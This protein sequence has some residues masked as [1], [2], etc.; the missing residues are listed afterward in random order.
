MTFKDHLARF[1]IGNISMRHIPGIALE[2]LEQ[3]MD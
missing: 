1:V 2:A 3:G